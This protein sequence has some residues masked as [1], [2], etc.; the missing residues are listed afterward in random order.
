MCRFTHSSSMRTHCSGFIRE[1]TF[2]TSCC[3]SCK[4]FNISLAAQNG[5][6]WGI[7]HSPWEPSPGCTEDAVLTRTPVNRSLTVLS[8]ISGRGHYL[9][10]GKLD[11]D[12][13]FFK[14]SNYLAIIFWICCLAIGYSACVRITSLRPMNRMNIFFPRDFITLSFYRGGE[15]VLFHWLDCYLFR[16]HSSGN[17][18]LQL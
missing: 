8:E 2:K 18:F 11:P 17:S 1:I 5:L 9:G 13:F 4:L 10:E 6:M 15:F 16:D 3:S 14:S 7:R 12:D